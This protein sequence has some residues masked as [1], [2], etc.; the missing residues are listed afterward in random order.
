MRE[1]SNTQPPITIFFSCGH[2]HVVLTAP[3][4]N[5]F[6]EVPKIGIL[7][8]SEQNFFSG[9]MTGKPADLDF[10]PPKNS[11]KMGKIGK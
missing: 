2:A 8:I 6:S 11:Q 10:Y 7:Q 4:V 3:I 9:K 5:S 1:A